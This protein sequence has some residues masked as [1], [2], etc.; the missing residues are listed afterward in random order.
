V[1]LSIELKKEFP[2]ARVPNTYRPLQGDPKVMIRSCRLDTTTRG[3]LSSA[4]H[5]WN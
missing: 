4:P 5:C 1:T 3:Y 2:L